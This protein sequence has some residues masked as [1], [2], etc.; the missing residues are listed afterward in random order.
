MVG[1]LVPYRILIVDDVPTVR[2]ALRWAFEEITDF[3][4]I[5][6]ADDG[7]AA[8]EQVVRL[9]PDVVIL[10]I[11]L[12]HFDGY[13]VARSLKALPQPPVVI[14]LTVHSDTAVRQ[15]S[16][17]LGVDGFVEKGAGWASLIRQIRTALQKEA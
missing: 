5:G 2:E 9:N 17:A 6:E 16:L 7:Q 11:E 14:F 1:Q 8:L 12:P 3:V 13:Q 4:I 15:R 10:D